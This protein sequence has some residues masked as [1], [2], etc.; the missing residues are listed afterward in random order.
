M[1]REFRV[2][3]ESEE[4]VRLQAYCDEL[5]RQTHG[6]AH[7]LASALLFLVRQELRPKRE[8][9]PFWARYESDGSARRM[10]D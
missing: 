2:K 9:D 8:N 1:S 6:R 10:S 4:V 7:D 5:N 3:L